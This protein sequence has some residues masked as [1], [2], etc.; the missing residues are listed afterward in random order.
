[1]GAQVAKTVSE[2]QYVRGVLVCGTGA[3]MAIVDNKV[4]GVRVV[5]VTDPFTAERR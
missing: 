5:C 4:P 2:E 3:G 1:M